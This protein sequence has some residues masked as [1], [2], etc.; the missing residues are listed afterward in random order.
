M[1]RLISCLLLVSA[2][3]AANAQCAM[4]SFLR[5]N[6]GLIYV[7]NAIGDLYKTINSDCLYTVENIKADVVCER[8]YTEARQLVRKVKDEQFMGN[9][10]SPAIAP[11][12]SLSGLSSISTKAVS[13]PNKYNAERYSIS[14]P[15]GWSFLESVQGADVY[16][17]ANDGSIA[18]T[19]LSF[20]TPCT[21]D[22][23]MDEVNSN[24]NSAGWKK[25]NISTTLCGVK[26]YKSIVTFTYSGMAVKQ[27]QYTLKKNGYVYNLNFGNDAAKVNSNLSLISIIA[28]SF[29]IN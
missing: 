29:V 7:G 15:A 13:L 1:K 10:G 11:S 4:N 18:F 26:C 5:Q 22:E 17:G 25:T 12:G 9:L 27:I 23:V 19:I 6:E 28:N 24:V 16:I 2:Y 21:L 8:I 3:I 20:S 14:Y